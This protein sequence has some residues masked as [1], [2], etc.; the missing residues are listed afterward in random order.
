MSVHLSRSSNLRFEIEKNKREKSITWLSFKQSQIKRMH[1]ASSF[2]LST[3]SVEFNH[4]TC[5]TP[6]LAQNE[7]NTHDAR[8]CIVYLLHLAWVYAVRGMKIA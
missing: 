3:L 8:I 5:A 7:Q 4:T 6:L 2:F 1:G